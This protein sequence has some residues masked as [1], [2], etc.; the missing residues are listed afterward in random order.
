MRTRDHRTARMLATGLFA[1]AGLG[2]AGCGTEG[3]E[4]GTDVEDVTDGEVLESSPPAEDAPAEGAED[5]IAAEGYVGPYDQD[6]SD[7]STTYV[8]QEVTLSAEVS[9]TVSP[10]A[11]TIAGAV[12]PLLIVESQELPAVDTGQVVEVTGTVQ[13]DF[14]VTDVEEDL[15]TELEDELF[16][17]YE[18]RPYVMATSA[19][20]VE[21]Q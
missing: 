11:F 15:G 8:G 13:D 3:S 14:A 21:E 1:V 4:T 19:E 7:R 16:S 20:I 18:G 5:G 12:D 17:D 10:E 2:L 6:F 9:E